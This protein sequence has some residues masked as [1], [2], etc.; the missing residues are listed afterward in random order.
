MLTEAAVVP[1]CPSVVPPVTL[2]VGIFATLITR[3]SDV[4]FA[5]NRYSLLGSTEGEDHEKDGSNIFT[6]HGDEVCH[7]RC[8]LNAN[9]GR[10]EKA[11]SRFLIASDAGPLSGLRK[12]QLS[13]DLALS[14]S[15]FEW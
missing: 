7:G 14:C 6:D 10:L 13:G 8:Q 5:G 2:V 1:D 3:I 15:L 11:L 12:C 9:P 4:H